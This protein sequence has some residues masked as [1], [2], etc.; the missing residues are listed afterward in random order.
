MIAD[1]LHLVVVE[2]AGLVQ[3]RI[4]H[5]HLADIVQQSRHAVIAHFCLAASEMA[6]HIDHQG[7]DGDRMKVGVFVL[8]LEPENIEQR[9][10]RALDHVD[11]LVHQTGD[12]RHPNR[13]PQADIAASAAHRHQRFGNQRL[14]PFAIA[15]AP[16]RFD[17]RSTS[18]WLTCRIASRRFWHNGNS[19]RLRGFRLGWLRPVRPDALFVIDHDSGNLRLIDASDIRRLY[20][21][22]REPEGVIQPAATEFGHIHSG[23]DV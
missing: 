21:E 8:L 6:R 10:R 17:Y 19:R 3:D 5:A 11:D 20:D 7:A 2:R 9:A 18:F 12:L 4:L 15:L 1:A 23:P 16:P 13:A 22:A 14:R